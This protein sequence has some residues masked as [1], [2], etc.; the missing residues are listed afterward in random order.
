MS[1]NLPPEWLERLNDLINNCWEYYGHS[2]SIGFATQYDEDTNL[3]MTRASPTIQ[4]LAG[5]PLDGTMRWCGFF[6]DFGAFCKNPKIFIL[7]SGVSSTQPGK[8]P[9]PYLVFKGEFEENAFVAYIYLQPMPDMNFKEVL[10]VTSN[11][12]TIKE[13]PETEGDEDDE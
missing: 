7:N 10:N 11:E 4:E 3:W 8:T 6:F 5:G 12:I 2:K 1:K 13:E 9:I